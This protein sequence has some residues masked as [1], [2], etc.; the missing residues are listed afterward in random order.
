MCAVP[1]AFGIS[2]PTS[3]FLAKTKLQPENVPVVEWSFRFF[4]FHVPVALTGWEKIPEAQA[5]VGRVTASAITPLVTC[6]TFE[7]L[8]VQ[9]LARRMNLTRSGTVPT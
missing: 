5:L 4:A 8:V 1:P 9:W 2:T 6:F 7:F 3:P